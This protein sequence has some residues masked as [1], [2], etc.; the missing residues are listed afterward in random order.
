MSTRQLSWGP[1]DPEPT[2]DV[3]PLT[4]GTDTWRKF[5]RSWQ[6]PYGGVMAWPELV[7]YRTLRRAHEPGSAEDLADEIDIHLE[8][9][10]E[11]PYEARRLLTL[12][13]LKLRG[14]GS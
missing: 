5:G 9:G 6:T 2:E 11:M 3:G 14:E 13:S 1:G 8:Q 4:D 12:A 10:W 7:K